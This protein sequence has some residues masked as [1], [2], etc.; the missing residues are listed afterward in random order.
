MSSEDFYMEAFL[1]I[2]WEFDWNKVLTIKDVKLALVEIET[3][4]SFY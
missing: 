3:R 4:R 1:H 2:A